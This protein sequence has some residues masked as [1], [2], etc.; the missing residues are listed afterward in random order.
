M[1]ITNRT[2]VF[3]FTVSDPKQ[4]SGRYGAFL[5]LAVCELILQTV[6]LWVSDGDS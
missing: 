4:G 6:F 2:K 1:V 3:S 5:R